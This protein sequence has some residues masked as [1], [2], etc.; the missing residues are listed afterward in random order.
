MIKPE[1]I[2]PISDRIIV[3]PII[4]TTTKSGI[5]IQIDTS[6]ETPTKGKVIAVGP[7]KLGQPLTIKVGD[8]VVYGAFNSGCNFPVEGTNYLVL[9]ESDVIAVLD[10]S[11]D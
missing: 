7:G 8:I 1:Q 10:D 3:D 9:R 6:R 2:H 11:T 5:I 4:E